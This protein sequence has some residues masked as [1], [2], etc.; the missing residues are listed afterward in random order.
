MALIDESHVSATVTCKTNCEFACMEK[1]H[2]WKFVG[3]QIPLM[4]K[5]KLL[6]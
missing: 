3:K 6:R 1:Y 2:F 4:D 5:I